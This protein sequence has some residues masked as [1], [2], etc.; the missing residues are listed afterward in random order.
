[1]GHWQAPDVQVAPVGQGFGQVPQCCSSVSRFTQV[2][3]HTSGSEAGQ[4]QA[5]ASQT[6]FVSGH[7]MPQAPQF[8][9]SVS[10]FTQA[11]GAAVG[12]RS[13]RD[14]G[15]AQAP[16]SQTSFASGQGWPHPPA[17]RQFS[18]S[19]WVSVQNVVQSSGFAPKQPQ[20]P[21]RQVEPGFA[22][23]V[24]MH[25]PQAPASVW[26]SRQRGLRESQRVVPPVHWQ[27]PPEQVPLPHAVPQPPQLFASVW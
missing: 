8:E 19:V 3:P 21:P 26:R 11:V 16:A 25:E 24:V 5:P 6:S 20:L 13:G 17:P 22:L 27:R 18:A 1:M 12:H 14:A 4:A 10:V 2:A 9:G 7:G 23:Q 15:H